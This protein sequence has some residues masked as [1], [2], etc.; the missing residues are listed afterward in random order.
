MPAFSTKSLVEG[1]GREAAECP[2]ELGNRIRSL[3]KDKKNLQLTY[4]IKIC[5]LAYEKHMF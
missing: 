4:K 2:G 5:L 1:W 3:I